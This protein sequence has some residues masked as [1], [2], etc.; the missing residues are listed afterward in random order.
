MPEKKPEDGA[1]SS[2]SLTQTD[3]SLVPADTTSD[4]PIDP[5][6]EP[7]KPVPPRPPGTES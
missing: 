3:D 2:E 7:G 1:E 4:D 5:M 6:D